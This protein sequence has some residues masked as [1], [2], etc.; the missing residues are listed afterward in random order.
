MKKN[1]LFGFLMLVPALLVAQED[2]SRLNNLLQQ[3]LDPPGK[4]P[5]RPDGRLQF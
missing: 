3:A 2:A 4:K 5:A 1:I